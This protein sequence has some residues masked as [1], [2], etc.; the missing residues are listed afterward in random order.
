MIDIEKT[1]P[2]TELCPV[3]GH[4][5]AFSLFDG[6]EQP[7]ATLAW[8]TSER[9]ALSQ[10]RYPLDFVQCPDCSHIWNCRFQYDAI[11]Y[12]DHPNRMF[13]AGT[14]WNGHIVET[15]N[16][17][18]S[19]LPESPVV[20]DIGCGEGQ[21]LSYLQHAQPN[22]SYHG[23]DPNIGKR[24]SSSINFSARLFEPISDIPKLEPDAIVIRHVLEHLT[25]PSA[26]L[27]EILWGCMDLQKTCVLFAE[28]P[29]I[30]R[31]LKFNRLA[32]FYY[33]HMSNFT[34]E[35]FTRILSRLGDPRK[36]LHGYGEEVA[37]GLVAIAPEEKS[38][39]RVA[40]ASKFRLAA[41]DSISR[42][43]RQLELLAKADK[44]IV[45]WGGTGK[46]AAFMHYYGLD[47][48]RFP[49]V[50]DSDVDKVGTH[51]P[52]MGQKIRH[53]DTLLE[54]DIHTIIIPMQWRARDVFAEIQELGIGFGQVLIEHAGELVDYVNGDH[55]Y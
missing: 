23:F 5:I 34:T 51:V 10:A 4:N 36:I 24:Q 21:F 28:V 12:R 35:S 17:L 37:Y 8:P 54:Q 22:G 9:E 53:R 11:P 27:E 44:S 7:L 16:L 45:I 43:G 32:D 55:P 49:L 13:N 48:E 46:A 26:F 52:G 2:R 42:V 31:V 3:C 38:K 1:R 29:C 30:D 6:G 50:V 20:V 40:E 18:L 47:I 33:E 41:L 15:A 14:A 25:H 39:N 19:E